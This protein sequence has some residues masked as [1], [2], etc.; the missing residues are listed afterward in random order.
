[1]F[2]LVALHHLS[3]ARDILALVPED[4]VV[5]THA[6]AEEWEQFLTAGL[7]G[8]VMGE[9]LLRKRLEQADLSLLLIDDEQHEDLGL[10]DLLRK[11]LS[12][13]K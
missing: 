1:A 13:A 5:L 11:R 2:K 10:K 6:M 9:N 4:G 7:A 12:S 8:D 3:D